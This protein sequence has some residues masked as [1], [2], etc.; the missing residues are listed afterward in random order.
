MAINFGSGNRS[1]GGWQYMR[2]RRD[3]DGNIIKEETKRSLLDLL[4][5][6]TF[7][8]FLGTAKSYRWMYVVS[9]AMG[10]AST[11]QSIFVADTFKRLLNAAPNIP[12]A[13][14]RELMA[15]LA[16]LAVARV[17]ITYTS[18][19][20]SSLLNESVVYSMRRTVLN[21]LQHLPLGWHENNH[22]SNA[23]NIM[24]QELE[25]TKSFVV[26]SLPEIIT[27]PFSFLAAVGYL[28]SVH[29]SLAL[30]A[31]L[32]GPLQLLSNRMLRNRMDAAW[33][34]Q[35]KVSRDV[36]HLIGETLQGIREVKSN[37]LEERVNRGMAE[38]ETRGVA[39]NVEMTQLR[40][41]RNICRTIPGEVANLVGIGLSAGLMAQ[42]KIGPGGLVAFFTLLDRV[43]A[44]FTTI[45]GVVNNLQETVSGAKKLY[46][47]MELPP[48]DTETGDEL[49]QDAPEI[50][51]ESVNF[52]YEKAERQ[53]LTD[54][55]F[56]VPAGKVLALVGPSGSGK[57]TLVK[58]LYR[59]YDAQEGEIRLHGRNIREFSMRSLR[60]SLALVSQE[61][62]LFD[63][64][65]RENITLGNLSATD[66][67]IERAARLAQADEFVTALPSGY[68]SEIGERGIKLS[69]GQKQRLSIAR[70]ILR[71]ASLLILDEPTSA[72]DV[73]TEAAFQSDLGEW[74]QH[75]TKIIIAHRLSTIR[76]ADYVL[77]LEEG[78]VVEFGTPAH[79]LREGGRFRTFWEKQDVSGMAID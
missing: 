7:R 51:F 54:V 15:T 22:S 13:L 47:V 62:F 55:T 48:E 37:Q 60:K 21:Q 30:V 26:S 33:E 64:T 73:E 74:A 19:W 75:C 32:V 1:S 27:L 14:L 39:Y 29:P 12:N 31:L 35:R 53:T 25:V 69:H 4:R 17:A 2:T 3:K 71:D 50:V 49:P 36:F 40:S 20:V 61:I 76:D 52:T 79:L 78:R 66:E 70:A 8:R 11:G 41:V 72:L 6:P 67:Q 77:F 23:Q 46:E 57:S 42:G 56:C 68:D 44:P 34:R 65:V 38:I 43:A 24:Y 18:G 63:S 16:L 58:L 59:F 10:L 45:V 28:F 9:I 5:D